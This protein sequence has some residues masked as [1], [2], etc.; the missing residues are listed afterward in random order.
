MRDE[1]FAEGNKQKLYSFCLLV[2]LRASDEY[3][4]P[5]FFFGRQGL[6][7]I[8]SCLKNPPIHRNVTLASILRS[9]QEFLAKEI[10]F[11]SK[12]Q[13]NCQTLQVWLPPVI[14]LP[15]TTFLFHRIQ[16][17]IPTQALRYRYGF[18]AKNVFYGKRHF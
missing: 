14:S 9:M 1:K 5:N 10:I 16:T 8:V 18:W 2:I 13:T 3:P 12:T 4:S 11:L 17:L 15:K 7:K 6:P